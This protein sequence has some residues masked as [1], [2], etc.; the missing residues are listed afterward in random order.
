MVVLIFFLFLVFV[1]PGLCV[2]T[3]IA[4][5]RLPG[6]GS[7][8]FFAIAL[9]A[10][11]PMFVVAV[12][13]P[14][15]QRLQ[16]EPRFIPLEVLTDLVL[17]GVALRARSNLTRAMERNWVWRQDA[18]LAMRLRLGLPRSP[19]ATREP[20]AAH[21][22]PPAGTTVPD[23]GFRPRGRILPPARAAAEE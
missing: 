19:E 8:C 9:S 7:L 23:T 6:A 20:T 15:L 16:E 10:L 14:H 11:S 21:R 17:L 18:E 12:L 3:G 4:G 5:L 13:P 2:A 1:C 22:E